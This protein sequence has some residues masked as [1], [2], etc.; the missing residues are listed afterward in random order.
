MGTEAGF[1]EESDLE[2]GPGRILSGRTFGRTA[3]EHD[4]EQ[5]MMQGQ[6][7]SSSPVL[8]S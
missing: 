6:K 5:K 8:S 1:A 2:R 3:E 4:A 7:R